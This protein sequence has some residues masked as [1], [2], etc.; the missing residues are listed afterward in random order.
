M[1]RRHAGWL[2]HESAC[3][4]TSN[5]CS[6]TLEYAAATSQLG[7]CVW[8]TAASAGAFCGA[9]AAAPQRAASASLRR[10]KWRTSTAAADRFRPAT[11]QPRHDDPQIEHQFMIVPVTSPSSG[12]SIPIIR[13]AGVH[14]LD[15]PRSR[16][17]LLTMA[18]QSSMN[19]HMSARS[20]PARAPAAARQTPRP[21]GAAA[22]VRGSRRHLAS[23]QAAVRDQPHRRHPR[24]KVHQGQAADREVRLP[25]HNYG[26]DWSVSPESSGWQKSCA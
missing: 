19:A 18:L 11:I 8:G 20:L 23:T 25:P 4:Q 16:A 22:A 3:Y 13:V 1:L 14:D 2:Q 26:T 17:A 9:T 6:P 15:P 5:I 10:F 24:Q 7:G 12:A 21:A